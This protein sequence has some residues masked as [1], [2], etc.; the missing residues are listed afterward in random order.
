M[1]KVSETDLYPPV[2]A[3]L[4]RQGYEVKAEIGPADV[5]ACREDEPP[6]IVELKLGFSLTLFHQ[7]IMRR[8]VCD[9]VYVAVPRGR[10]RAFQ[11]SLLE[12]RK[13]C[14]LLGLGLLTV[15]LEDGL[16]EPQLDPGPYAP[17]KSPARAA[18]LLREFEK[19][20]G[21]PNLGGTR[22]GVM[23]A[24]RQDAM[25]CAAYLGEHGPTKGAQVAKATG[26]SR[27]TRMMADNHYGWFKR[28][29]KG[30]YDLSANGRKAL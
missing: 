12:N 18:R 19:R 6:V 23:T 15:R 20:E 4:E 16:V 3:F 11:K 30:I 2:K 14:R 9:A 7:A 10:G 17:R 21:D 27:A 13:L 8:T 28:V 1:A 24:Y 29:E 5:V 25:K 26:V 22:G